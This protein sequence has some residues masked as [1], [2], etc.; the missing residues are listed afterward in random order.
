MGERIA[1]VGRITPKQREGMAEHLRLLSEGEPHCETWTWQVRPCLR[2]RLQEQISA[3]GGISLWVMAGGRLSWRFWV[4][5]ALFFDEDVLARDPAHCTAPDPL[6]IRTLLVYATGE[7]V[8]GRLPA[9]L[10]DWYTRQDFRMRGRGCRE[11]GYV[12]AE[13]PHW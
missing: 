10:V 5:H 2:E 8:A 6:P 9:T 7:E 13:Q 12:V 4:S 1:L 11:F 3:D